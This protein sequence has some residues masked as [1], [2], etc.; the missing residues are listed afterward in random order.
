MS[1]VYFYHSYRVHITLF[2]G[3]GMNWD[4]EDL[5]ILKE[6]YGKIP[7]KE[8]ADKL[9]RSENSIRGQAQVHGLQKKGSG[10]KHWNYEEDLKLYNLYQSKYK[11]G[12]KA[13]VMD[14]I[15]KIM[16]RSVNSI[17]S[18]LSSKKLR[19]LPPDPEGYKPVK[20]SKTQ[21]NMMFYK[22]YNTQ[23]ASG[24]VNGGK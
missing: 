16:G 4:P 24:F 10:Y 19:Y 11:K 15:S 14:E 23:V 3:D 9:K 7:A 18:R 12:R 1:H 21:H 6:N 2:E 20:K 17:E 22:I 13:K 5:I 8:L